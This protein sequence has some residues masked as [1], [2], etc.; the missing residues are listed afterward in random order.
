[1]VK[2]L[3]A[4]TGLGSL[5]LFLLFQVIII[6]KSISLAMKV[7]IFVIFIL[8]LLSL[9]SLKMAESGLVVFLVKLDGVSVFIAQDL[10]AIAILLV[11]LVMDEKLE[12]AELL[13]VDFE[14]VLRAF[15]LAAHFLTLVDFLVFLVVHH[16]LINFFE[17]LF[18]INDLVAV[19]L[20]DL[21]FFIVLIQIHLSLVCLI[22]VFLG[23]HH[24][25]SLSLVGGHLHDLFFGVH[26]FF[27]LF[28]I[29][30]HLL[31]LLKDF[32]LVFHLAMIELLVIFEALF[33]F[34]HVHFLIHLLL[35]SIMVDV[36]TTL[37]GCH[38]LQHELLLSLEFILIF[39]AFAEFALPN[40]VFLFFVHLFDLFLFSVSTLVLGVRREVG[41]GRVESVVVL[42]RDEQLSLL[43]GEVF[44][45]VQASFSQDCHVPLQLFDLVQI[46]DECVRNL[47]NEE[48]TVCN[49]EFNVGFD[50][51]VDIFQVLHVVFRSHQRLFTSLLQ[52]RGIA[53]KRRG[54]LDSLLETV[55]FDKAINLSFELAFLVSFLGLHLGASLLDVS[56]VLLGGRRLFRILVPRRRIF[57]ASWKLLLLHGWVNDLVGLVHV[58]AQLGGGF[59]LVEFK[60]HC[61][62]QSDS[63]LASFHLRDELLLQLAEVRHRSGTRGMEVEANVGGDGGLGR[64]QVFLL[65][66]TRIVFVL[67]HAWGQLGCHV[68]LLSVSLDALFTFM[69]V[70]LHHHLEPGHQDPPWHDPRSE[71]SQHAS[72]DVVH[73][74]K[75][76]PLG[77]QVALME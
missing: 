7:N 4:K 57:A 51:I 58:C 41:G 6:F 1:M 2:R 32:I 65:P 39:L 47:L 5:L 10:A 30:V 8:H 21:D 62:S 35:D 40:I 19:N 43:V 55:L 72:V 54:A 68:R 24:V 11:L 37:S 48:G 27:I 74:L 34:F 3:T 38:L 16:I 77:L 59:G 52:S 46:V 28:I 70:P 56:L 44:V 63:L 31:L 69:L 9:E 15:F 33:A 12:L 66:K 14:H 75:A 76:F 61:L 17:F 45:R 26:A 71:L 22:V 50:I 36:F 73:V 18:V 23:D 42:G 29:I 60:R 13:F 49:I 25:L 64:V 53:D 20:V 67:L